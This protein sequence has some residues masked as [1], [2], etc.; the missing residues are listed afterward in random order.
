MDLFLKTGLLVVKIFIA[1]VALFPLAVPAIPAF[2]L[3]LTILEQLK[4]IQNKRIGAQIILT[5]IGLI[6][7]KS[8]ITVIGAMAFTASS[9]QA[10]LIGMY[11]TSYTCLKLRSALKH[12]IKTPSSTPLSRL[13]NVYKRIW[14]LT[15][16]FNSVYEFRFYV[17]LIGLVEL[18]AIVGL[19][20]AFSFPYD[21]LLMVPAVM[22]AVNLTIMIAVT[23]MLTVASTVWFESMELLENMRVRN[24]Q[25][26]R[27][28]LVKV[29]IRS[30][31]PLKIK[32]GSVN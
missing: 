25:P 22:M 6:L 1:S 15:S 16:L 24:K 9:N 2:P 30:L 19:Y 7:V 28:R 13:V 23:F 17:N 3:G 5:V 26:N 27:M 29:R 10:Y 4:D 32:I 14:I 20:G 21:T 8:G 31:P 12:C 18:T 11:E